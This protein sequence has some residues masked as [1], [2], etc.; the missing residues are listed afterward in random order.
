MCRRFAAIF[1]LMCSSFVSLASAA[2]ALHGRVLDPSGQPLAGVTIS[3]EGPAGT[4]R[5][6]STGDDGSYT[7]ENIPPGRYDVEALLDQFEPVVK[8]DI[9]L[10]ADTVTVDLRLSLTLL[11]QSITVNAPALTNVL[12]AADAASPIAVT[13]SVIDIAMLPN[14]QFDDVLPLMP[15]VVRGPDG[16]IAV[17]GARATSSGLF[18][19][20]HDTDDPA[21]GGPGVLV[22]LAAVDALQVYAGG[23]PAEFGGASGGVTSV[24]TRVGGD[25]LNA[26]VDSFFPRLLYEDSGITGVAFWDPNMGVSGPLS[27]G[28]AWFQQALSYRFDRNTFTTL[29][30][31][32]HNQ[33]QELLSWTQVDTQLTEHH[34]LHAWFNADPRTTNHTHITAFTPA[35]TTPRF[36]QG[37]TNAGLADRV[38]AGTVLIDLSAST[39]STR[40]NVIPSGDQP[41]VMSHE[42]AEGNYFDTQRRRAA[43]AAGMVRVEWAPS[44]RQSLTTGLTVSR[45]SLTQRVSARDVVMLRS[46]GAVARTV[47]FASQPAASVA[48]TTVGSFIQDR[49]TPLSWVTLD[50]GL[51]ADWSSPVQSVVISPRLGWTIATQQ[52]RTTVSGTVGRYADNLP[53]SALAFSSLPTRVITRFEPDGDVATPA[54]V[55]NAVAPRLALSTAI[56]WDAQLNR[57]LGAWQVRV[58][59]EERRGIR[60]LAVD[61]PIDSLLSPFPSSSSVLSSGGRS[62]ARSLE[63]TAGVH[64]RSGSEW[65][66]SYVRAATDGPQNSLDAVE[67]LLRAPFLQ[68][69]LNGPL[70]SDVPHRLLTWGV[71][72]LPAGLT[73]APFLEARS[74]FPYTAIDDEWVMSGRPDEYRLPGTASLDVSATKVV[75]LPHHLPQAHVGVKLYNVVSVNTEREVQRDIERADFGTTY[76]PVPRDFSIV[77]EFLWQKR[78]AMTGS[79]TPT[80]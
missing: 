55:S 17:A 77:F 24:V 65:Y 48:A 51:R 80:R 68:A 33:F 59:Y 13:R 67:G 73:V 12:G 71:F 19:N 23:A 4:T 39:L 45:A 7:F 50:A 1:A 38:T 42:L 30:G 27:R 63:F 72:H 6:T 56:R 58:R 9:E 31:A 22:P 60:E 18:V 70:P 74:G 11:D 53:L 57:R 40:A 32:E 28:H 47:S 15:N 44:S 36:E 64:T 8:H 75:A 34:R 46:D 66:A 21:R 54:V 52:S 10:V 79:R 37:G 69:N 35:A 43:R 5:S 61:T 76:D 78:Q 62:L 2:P 25:H 14:S 3:L 20:G 41:Y 49:W 16:F 29:A 26:S